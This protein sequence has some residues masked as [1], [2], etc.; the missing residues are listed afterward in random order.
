MM[1]IITKSLAD[2]SFWTSEPISQ[3]LETR[4]DTQLRHFIFLHHSH[5]SSQHNRSTEA[6]FL[7]QAIMASSLPEMPLLPITSQRTV[8]ACRSLQ[9]TDDDI[10]VC[11]YPKSGTTWTQNLVCR[12]L[13]V[14]IGMTIPE[15]WHLSQSA[16]FFEL[17]QYWQGKDRVPPQT[18]LELVDQQTGTKKTH[19]VFN[20]HLR[21]H[22]LPPNARC[23]YVIRDALDVLTSFFFHLANMA[24][25]DGGYAETAEQFCSDFVDGTVLYG[26]WQDHL[27][28]WLGISN[29]NA[30]NV[31]VL[32]FEDMKHNLEAEAAKVARFLGVDETRFARVVETAVP[33]C[34]FSA[35]RKERS[36][37]TP[38]SVEWKNGQ[39][40]KSYDN[41]VR[42]GRIGDGKEFL[43]QY[44]SDELKKQWAKDLATA[45]VRW[46]DA[47]VDSQ[48][49]ERYL[50]PS[51]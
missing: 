3:I 28:A 34:T 38:K 33:H 48:I 51:S 20:T 12:L 21:P 46:L 32:H 19:R 14:S 49:I 27:E 45:R 36:R 41:F 5:L 9:V 10:F 37:Y 43:N 23:I 35:M 26:K 16:P 4:G 25:A 39:D 2:Y 11:S 17:D 1:D 22:Q 8:E 30:S 13:A 47:Q 40:G 44:F 6:M 31:L 24:E 50:G 7:H 15:D 29:R 42:T 18:P